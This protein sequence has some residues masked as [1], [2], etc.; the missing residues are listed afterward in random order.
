MVNLS[1]GDER[2]H[3]RTKR[4]VVDHD[5]VLNIKWKARKSGDIF[6]KLLPTSNKN[7]N[8][9]LTITITITMAISPDNNNNDNNGNIT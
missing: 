7:V 1:E 8:I 9:T 3:K 2:A 4:P 5:P 6:F